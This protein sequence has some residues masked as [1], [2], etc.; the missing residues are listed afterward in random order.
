MAFQGT[1]TVLLKLHEP[2]H[3]ELVRRTKLPL[4]RQEQPLHEVL[5]RRVPRGD[6]E[7]GVAD[8][9]A[10]RG[11]EEG[12]RLHHVPRE[13][14]EREAEEEPDLAHEEP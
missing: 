6:E 1:S 14:P 4:P 9:Q 2:L 8:E 10:G 13:L 3:I 12:D 11:G 5:V 7:V